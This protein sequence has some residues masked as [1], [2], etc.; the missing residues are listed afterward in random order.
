MSNFMSNDD[1]LQVLGTYAE[2]IKKGKGVIAVRETSPAT[3]AHAVGDYIRFNGLTYKVKSAI[4]I[5]DSLILNTNIEAN[6]LPNGTTIFTPE[7]VGD[8]TV[9]FLNDL[10]DVAISNPQNGQ[11]PMYNSTTG[12]FENASVDVTNPN[13][14]D[15]PWFTV[16]QRGITSMS[17]EIGNVYCVDRWMLGSAYSY[18]FTATSDG[19]TFTNNDANNRKAIYQKSS[20]NLE[21]IKGKTVTLSVLFKDGSIVSVT[22][23]CPSEV[24]GRIA[25]DFGINST[26]RLYVDTS[27]MLFQILV[28]AGETLYVRAMKLE[29]GSVSTLHLDTEPDYTTELLKCQRYYYRIF[30]FGPNSNLSMGYIVGV[31]ST[32]LAIAYCSFVLPVPLRSNSPTI[33]IHGNFHIYSPFSGTDSNVTGSTFYPRTNSIMFAEFYTSNMSY[34]I[35]SPAVLYADQNAYIEFNADL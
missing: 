22:G 12:K 21:Y 7:T 30:V 27:N 20:P 13:L 10:G 6:G 15:N 33:A 1:A 17:P 19:F 26:L 11:V 31:S 29:I 32:A 3:A 28:G 34:T 2:D 16:N 8:P 35:G 24:G 23:V 18:T 9:A 5:G 25:T 14:L 4:S